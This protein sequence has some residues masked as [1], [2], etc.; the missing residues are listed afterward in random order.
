MNDECCG[1]CG[2]H[3]RVESG[4]YVCTQS[5]SEAF[6]LE[7]AYDDRCDEWEKREDYR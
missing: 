2:W 6:G 5:E 1:T 7:T 3:V 4:D